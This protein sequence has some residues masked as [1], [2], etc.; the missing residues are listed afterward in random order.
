MHGTTAANGFPTFIK[1]YNAKCGG[2]VHG[3]GTT[4]LNIFITQILRN[5]SQFMQIRFLKI[6]DKNPH[7]RL[8]VVVDSI[9]FGKIKFPFPIETQFP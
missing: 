4:T 6:Q 5:S 2:R 1:A 8:R 3:L 7:A 9:S